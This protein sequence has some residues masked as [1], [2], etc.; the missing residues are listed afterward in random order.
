MV[1]LRNKNTRGSEGYFLID[2]AAAAIL[3]LVM[4]TG[5]SGFLISA[6]WSVQKI[7]NK[8]GKL[9]TAGNNIYGKT[10]DEY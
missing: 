3:I 4:I 1:K 2:T 6:S 9:L 7:G 5:I 10:Y 8:A